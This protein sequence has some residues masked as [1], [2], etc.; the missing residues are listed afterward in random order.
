M[1]HRLALVGKPGEGSLSNYR[2]VFIPD[3]LTSDSTLA[4]LG[5]LS[6]EVDESRRSVLRYEGLLEFRSPRATST[7][8]LPSVAS[9]YPSNPPIRLDSGRHRLKKS[10]ILRVR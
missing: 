1:N 9:G 2:V 6:L 5:G 8:P 7:Q 4:Q 3:W 10:L